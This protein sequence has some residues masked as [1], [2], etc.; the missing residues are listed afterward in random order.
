MK[1]RIFDIRIAEGH[2]NALIEFLKRTPLKGEEVGVFSEVVMM[3]QN[4]P[5]VQ[6]E[7]EV[8]KT[9]A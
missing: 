6:A 3:I 2:R 1:E 5:E 9:D 7:P 4:A 8:S